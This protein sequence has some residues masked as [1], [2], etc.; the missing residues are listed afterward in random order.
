MAEVAGQQS[1]TV[2]MRP[3]SANLESSGAALA[4]L[5]PITDIDLRPGGGCPGAEAGDLAH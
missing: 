1:A 3:S 5:R 2:T 4:R